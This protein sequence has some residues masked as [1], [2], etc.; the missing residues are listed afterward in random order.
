VLEQGEIHRIQPEENRYIRSSFDVFRQLITIDFNLDISRD[1]P[2]NDRTKTKAELLGD[3]EAS[4]ERMADYRGRIAALPGGGAA[5]TAERNHLE[6]L[7]EAEEREINKN[8]IEIYKKDSIP[9]AAIIFVMI[10]SSLGILVRRS[11]VSIGIGLS[12]GFFT[13]YYMFLIAGES[14]GDRLIVNPWLAMWLPNLFF[15]PVALALVWYANRR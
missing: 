9:F 10:G 4:R 11:G 15:G 13:L 1:A 6:R 7:I 3:V 14:A 2:K 5:L 12:I 8:Y